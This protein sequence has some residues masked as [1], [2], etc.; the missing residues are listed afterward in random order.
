M[1]FISSKRT[2][3]F[4][5]LFKLLWVSRKKRRERGEEMRE[6]RRKRGEKVREKEKTKRREREK[7]N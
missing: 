1:L 4:D 7:K 6:E 3:I 5:L 2:I